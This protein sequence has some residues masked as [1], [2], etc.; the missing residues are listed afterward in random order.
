MSTRNL[1]WACFL[2]M[3]VFAGAVLAISDVATAGG[4][5][6]P[7]TPPVTTATPTAKDK[8]IFLHYEFKNVA[9]TSHSAATKPPRPK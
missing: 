4:K 9:I 6:N 2:A 1:F 3:F 8:P 5:S 7:G